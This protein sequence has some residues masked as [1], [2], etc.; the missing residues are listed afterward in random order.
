VVGLGEKVV[1]GGAS[2]DF[3]K[4]GRK[5]KVGHFIDLAAAYGNA[6]ISQSTTPS[7]EIFS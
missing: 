4:H 3:K 1:N 6:R 5:K 2:G 7:V